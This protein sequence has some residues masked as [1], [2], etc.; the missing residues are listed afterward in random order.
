VRIYL[1]RNKKKKIKKISL[2]EKKKILVVPFAAMSG[3]ERM[4]VSI[5]SFSLFVLFK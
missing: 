2:R 3:A 1:T 4:P 5:L